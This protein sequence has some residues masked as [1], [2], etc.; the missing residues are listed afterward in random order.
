MAKKKKETPKPPKKLAVK[1]LKVRTGVRAGAGAG[2]G[3]GGGGG[4]GRGGGGLT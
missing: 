1:T 3:G 2:S 4:A